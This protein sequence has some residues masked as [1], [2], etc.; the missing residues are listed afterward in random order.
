MTA[1]RRLIPSA[2]IRETL[3]LL[4]EYGVDLAASVI[5]IS[6]NGVR[7]SPPANESPAPGNAFD[8]WKKKDADHGRAARR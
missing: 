6:G 8:Q 4:R 1:R 2:E 5:D 7:V 3:D